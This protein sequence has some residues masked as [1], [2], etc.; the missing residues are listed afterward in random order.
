MKTR[1]KHSYIVC[2]KDN[3]PMGLGT[4]YEGRKGPTLWCSPHA[5][6]VFHDRRT[7]RHAIDRTIRSRMR[8]LVRMNYSG[9]SPD[10]FTVRHNYHIWRL[11]ES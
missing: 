8:W 11:G 10:E 6:T 5:V 3:G 1:R 4:D 9:S 2:H 7:C